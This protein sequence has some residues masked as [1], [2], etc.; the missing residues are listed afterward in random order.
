MTDLCATAGITDL[1]L[2]EFRGGPEPGLVTVNGNGH[3]LTMALPFIPDAILGPWLLGHREDG[4]VWSA[5][6]RPQPRDLHG[7]ILAPG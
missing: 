4:N 5:V 2:V 1:T 6:Y 3:A 7:A